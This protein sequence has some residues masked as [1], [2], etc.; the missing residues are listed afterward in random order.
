M[1]RL[2]QLRWRSRRHQT[3]HL[4]RGPPKCRRHE[5]TT[6]IPRLSQWSRA[7][8]DFWDQRQIDSL[9]MSQHWSSNSCQMLLDPARNRLPFPLGSTQ[10][11]NPAKRMSNA[12]RLPQCATTS[13]TSICVTKFNRGRIPVS[14]IMKPTARHHHLGKSARGSY[15]Q[16][17]HPRFRTPEQ[18]LSRRHQP[19]LRHHAG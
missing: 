19:Q 1:A 16:V 10:F 9:I 11:V 13:R 15:W 7:D 12:A 14:V 8:R 17:L 6:H 4:H 2:S 18:F 3:S 5:P